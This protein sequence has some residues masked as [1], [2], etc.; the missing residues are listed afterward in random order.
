[1]SVV[2]VATITPKPGQEDAVR[3]AVLATVPKVH[4]E[5]GC[6]L[7]ALHEEQ[8]PDSGTRFVMVERWASG[9]ALGAH[10]KGAALAELGAAL[11]GKVAAPPDVRRMTAL[12]AGQEGKGAV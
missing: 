3:D 12:P 4:A 7:Y 9:E 6:E 5:E 8:V 10:S 11:A 2:L 1:M